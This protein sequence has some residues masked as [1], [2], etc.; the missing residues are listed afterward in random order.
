M[1]NKKSLPWFCRVY[2]F[3]LTIIKQEE[4]SANRCVY[5]I[6]I[7]TR[8]RWRNDIFC[9]IFQGLYIYP[10]K[11][12]CFYVRIKICGASSFVIPTARCHNI[13]FTSPFKISTSLI[14]YVIIIHCTKCVSNLMA[15]RTNSCD[16]GSRITTKFWRA[17]IA[18]YQH[19][20]NSFVSKRHFV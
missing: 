7:V 12:I 10:A 15:W 6:Y 9:I 4:I 16:T 17:R 14:I 2:T 13:P 5:P 18:I 3:R 19:S 20:P 11:I 1:K 8:S